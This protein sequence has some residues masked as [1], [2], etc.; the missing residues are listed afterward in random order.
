M[1]ESSVIILV[2]LLLLIFT[3]TEVAYQRALFLSTQRTLE[4]G[5]VIIDAMVKM[6]TCSGTK[7]V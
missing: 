6:N 2:L 1:T 3:G 5:S 4:S 7:V